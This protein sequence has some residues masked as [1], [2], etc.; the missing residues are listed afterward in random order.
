MS[1]EYLSN[2]IGFLLIHAERFHLCSVRRW[3]FQ[4]VTDIFLLGT[5][6]ES[7][8]REIGA[9]DIADLPANEWLESTPLMRALRRE[10]RGRA[11][12]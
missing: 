8:A 4:E 6:S 5:S 2:V 11:N 7:L 10:L 3:L 9:P 12:T 1:T